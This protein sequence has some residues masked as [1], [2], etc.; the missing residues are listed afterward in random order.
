MNVLESWLDTYIKVPQHHISSFQDWMYFGLQKTMESQ[1]LCSDK[2]SWSFL[3]ARISKPELTPLEAHIKGV[4]YDAE[5]LVDIE[6]T[7]LID[8]QVSILKN[9]VIARTPLIIL[10][11]DEGSDGIGG[12]F[13]I[14]NVERVLVTQERA[15]YNQPIVTFAKDS[16]KKNRVKTDDV[17][18][19]KPSQ[20]TTRCSKASAELISDY[21]E[22]NS[23]VRNTYN[24]QVDVVLVQVNL[25][26]IS[27]SSNHSCGTEVALT[28]QSQV[29]IS[30]TKFRGRIPVSLVLKALGCTTLDHFKWACMQDEEIATNLY[31]CSMSASSKVDALDKLAPRLIFTQRSVESFKMDAKDVLRFLTFELFPHLGLNTTPSITAVYIGMLVV[32]CFEARRTGKADDRDSLQFKRFEPAGVLI[33]DLFEQLVKKWITVMKKFCMKKNNIIVGIQPSFL[34]KRLL[35]CFSTGSWGALLSNYK[36][37]GVSQPRA[38]SSYIA[39]L[40]HL[41]RVSNPISKETRN[42]PVRQINPSQQYYLCPCESPEGQ[43]VGIVTNF[44]IGATITNEASPTMLIDAMSHMLRKI[45]LDQEFNHLVFLNGRIIGSTFSL[46][47]FV[48]EF[49]HLRKIGKFDGGINRGMV[50]IGICKDN[51][52]I[53]CDG[54]RVTRLV[55]NVADVGHVVHW[56]DGLLNGELQYVDPFEQEFGPIKH[57]QSREIHESTLFGITA[58]SI[59]F[60]EFQPVPR[61][62]YATGM[63]KHTICSIGPMQAEKFGTTLYIGRRQQEPVVTTTMSRALNLNDYPT[64]T[65][66]IVAICPCDGYNQ[67]DAIVINKS[68]LDRG[69]FAS[70]IYKTHCVEEEYI[71]DSSKC[72]CIP[73]FETRNNSYNYCMLDD[74]GI[75]R[76]GMDVVAGD[77]IVGQVTKNNKKEIDKDSKKSFRRVVD[78][79][80]VVS[81]GEEGR[82]F[83][84]VSYTDTGK[85][86]VKIVIVSQLPV[87]CGDKFASRFGQKGVCGKIANACDLPFCEDGTVPDI[88]MNPLALPSRMTI[89]T[90][91]EALFGLVALK[92]QQSNIVTTFEPVE[93]IRATM[94]LYG[95][96]TSG[97]CI[98]R[99]PVN[100]K[101]MVPIFVGPMYYSRL[102]H[103]AEPKCYAR[104]IGVTSKLTR[105]P[106][107]GRSRQGGLRFG[108][109]ETDAMIGLKMSHVLHD[110]LYRCSDPFFINVCRCMDLALNKNKCLCG[111]GP[112]NIERV[113]LAFSSNLAFAILR[114][115]G[116]M[117]KF[118][119]YD[120]INDREDKMSDDD[121]SGDD[122]DDEDEAM[123][124]TDDGSEEDD[125]DKDLNELCEMDDVIMEDDDDDE[126]DDD[127][128]DD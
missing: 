68:S 62:V 22:F 85:R 15:G 95:I 98:M 114:A 20:S 127:F 67:E 72:F 88:F 56:R 34:T 4:T 16:S 117:V 87:V 120:R 79:S 45:I 2:K 28:R 38:T 73:P 106:T 19:T 47:D 12:Y 115:M 93:D 105:Q 41:Y 82:V 74:S 123:S 126:G 18:S 109:M 118:G 17:F 86:A 78:S 89:P 29:L 103:L 107:D 26:S 52:Y 54:G 125:D 27:E 63:Q 65:N 69:L 111:A 80:I 43:T 44:A 25:R 40:S 75:V 39:Q 122:K 104:S 46:D 5:I 59:P 42:Q 8:G 70:D 99:N 64:G 124:S 61:A 66:V 116:C 53:W 77:V 101:K 110:R 30:N 3:N 112:E 58:S 23:S 13:Q 100:G 84:V 96:D 11:N 108:E 76:V 57:S 55:K 97:T 113:K 48:N 9:V 83:R 49:L 121:E 37:M 24:K 36:R 90:I 1:T 102:A 31:V 94:E 14:K 128:F 35:Y 81:K 21:V 32:K 7:N 60:I 50:S 92:T 33:R 71:G 51:I 91:M 10:P 6:E 119:L